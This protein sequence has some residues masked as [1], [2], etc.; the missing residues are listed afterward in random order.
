MGSASGPARS[1]ARPGRSTCR[2]TAAASRSASSAPGQGC[3]QR[4]SAARHGARLPAG[5]GH[6]Q[7]VRRRAAGRVSPE[8]PETDR[9]LLA[10]EYADFAESIRG[11][12]P[13]EVDIDQGT[14]SVALSYALLESG[15]LGRPRHRRGGAGRAESMATEQSIQRRDGAGLGRLISGSFVPVFALRAKNRHKDGNYHEVFS[16][17]EKRLQ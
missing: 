3:D 12:H 8:L 10:V 7:P 13:P 4:R 9:K 17:G 1:T 14:R 6:G 2:W 16:H 5:R 11:E 15:V